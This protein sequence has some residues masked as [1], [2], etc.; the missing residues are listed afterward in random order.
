[1]KK[2]WKIGLFALAVAAGA[3]LGMTTGSK[4]TAAMPC[5]SGCTSSFNQCKRSCPV[6]DQACLGTCLDKYESC[7][8]YCSTSC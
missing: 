1:M 2:S 6:S 4:E 8:D 5:C 7:S 3:V